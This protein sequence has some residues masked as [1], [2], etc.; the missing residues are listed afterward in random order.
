MQPILNLELRIAVVLS[1][2]LESR[3]V[4]G[5][6]RNAYLSQLKLVTPPAY[7]FQVAQGVFD[8]E[9]SWATIK[10][11]GDKREE[12][13]KRYRDSTEVNRI[14]TLVITAPQRLSAG[15]RA[16]ARAQRTA[17]ALDPSIMA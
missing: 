1:W 9:R 2:P 4:N 11:K 3:R 7:L 12:A 17:I 15:G 14:D 10:R 13:K 6:E 16:L 8:Q 5:A